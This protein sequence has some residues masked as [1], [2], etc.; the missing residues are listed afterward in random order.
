MSF[1]SKTFIAISNKKIIYS[2]VLP[3]WKC[4]KH[5]F[6]RN[7]NLKWLRDNSSVLLG[8]TPRE[9]LQ[10]Q[11]IENRWRAELYYSWTPT[12]QKNG[13]CFDESSLKI[14]KSAFSFILKALFD[15][16]VLKLKFLSWL[17]DHVKKSTARKK[18]MV[19]FQIYDVTT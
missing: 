9:K 19:N 2:D 11:E 6:D 14:M 8:Q 4:L 10:V 3:F 7:H 17:F 15:L 1:R 12:F 16:K 13:T 5:C 18:Y